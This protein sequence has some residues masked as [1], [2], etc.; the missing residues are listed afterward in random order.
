MVVKKSCVAAC[1]VEWPDG[2]GISGRM[3]VEWVAG[4]AWNRWSD[5]HGMGGQMTVE[6]ACY[7]RRAQISIVDE[8]QVCVDE[9]VLQMT[10]RVNE[11]TLA[12]TDITFLTGS[13]K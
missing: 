2:R 11:D 9:E 12:I 1:P 3:R 4:S 8:I 10:P 5:A 13:K 7:L 6:S